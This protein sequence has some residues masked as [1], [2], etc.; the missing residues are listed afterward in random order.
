MMR[1]LEAL[2]IMVA[3]KDRKRLRSLNRRAHVTVS[4]PKPSR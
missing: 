3:S 1:P 4:R 2:R